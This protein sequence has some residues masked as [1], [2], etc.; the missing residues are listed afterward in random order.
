MLH[1]TVFVIVTTLLLV[2]ILQTASAEEIPNWIK[3]KIK[4]WT[5]NKID[6]QGFVDSMVELDKRGLIKLEKVQTVA[7]TYKLPKYGETTF[8]TI[9]GRVSDIGQ[10][11]PVTL[12]ITRPDGLRMQYTVPVLQSGAYSTS[13][14]LEY[15][16]PTGTYE[17]T[18][19]HAGRELYPYYFAVQKNSLIPSWLKSAAKWW[20]DGMVSD[21]DFLYGIQYLIDQRI[22]SIQTTSTDKQDSSLDVTVHGLKAV[23]RGT[24]QNL[25][26]HVENFKENV[27]GATV[28]VRVEDYGENVLKE[29]K[30]ETDSDGNY[31]VSYELS[32]D[33][34]DI[35][36]FLVYVDVTDGISSKTKI[37]SFQVYCICGEPNCKCRN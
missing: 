30:G 32:K 5:M 25:D 34:T 14:P 4:L 33:Y 19:Y 26:I 8:V 16:F 7:T 1:K 12:I 15:S 37:F 6:D 31:S 29:F 22:L 35:K 3:S 23:R 21:A 28:F 17:V 9:S 10:T 18:G 13:I 2:T 11:S 20:S 24:M 27:D 36:T